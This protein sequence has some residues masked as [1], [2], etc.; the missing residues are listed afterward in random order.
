MVLLKVFFLH[1][2]R[3]RTFGDQWQWLLQAGVEAFPLSQT[4]SIKALKETHCTNTGQGKSSTGLIHS[5]STTGLFQWEEV[6][7]LRWQYSKVLWVKMQVK[8]N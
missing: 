1:L 2:F 4:N 8:V 3:K 6:L 5:S 7:T